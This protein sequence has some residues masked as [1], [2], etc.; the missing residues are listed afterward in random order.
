MATL[1]ELHLWLLTLQEEDGTHESEGDVRRRQSEDSARM[2]V[3]SIAALAAPT[4]LAPKPARPIQP[5]TS[6]AKGREPLLYM[7]LQPDIG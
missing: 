6:L 2:L 5:G 3:H 7:E 4:A 1:S